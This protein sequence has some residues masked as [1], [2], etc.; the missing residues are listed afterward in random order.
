MVCGATKPE[1]VVGSGPRGGR[2]GEVLGPELGPR[3]ARVDVGA[4]EGDGGGD[5]GVE[6]RCG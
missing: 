5:A 2:E 3:G 1:A 4:E 6:L